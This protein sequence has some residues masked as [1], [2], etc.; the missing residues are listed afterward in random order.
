MTMVTCVVWDA[1]VLVSLIC[2]AFCPASWP[3][4]SSASVKFITDDRVLW[5]ICGVN[6]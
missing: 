2:H 6:N 4:R 5:L 1:F 3:S